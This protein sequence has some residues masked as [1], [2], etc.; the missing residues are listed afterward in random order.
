M[1]VPLVRLSAVDALRGFVA[2]GRRMSIAQGAEDLCLTP[3]ALSKQ[4]TKLEESL[5]VRLLVRGH[6]S[7]A[8]TK[9]GAE[10]YMA[11]SAAF[12]QMQDAVG[13]I[14]PSATG[15]PVTITASIGVTALW[16]LPRL[17]RLHADHPG[18]DVRVAAN[19]A[20]VDLRT[21]DIDLSIRYC[22][23]ADVPDGAVRLFGE[24]IRPVASPLLGLRAIDS[25]EALAEQVL[26]EFDDPRHPWLQW[27]N[28]VAAAG[29]TWKKPRGI[30][31]LNQYDMVI[32]AAM[33]GQGVALGRLELLGPLL[34]AGQLRTPDTP[35]G[36]LPCGHGYWL[37]M[38]ER[39]PRRAVRQIAEWL[40]AQA[41]RD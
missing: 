3:S 35:L 26:L 9:E 8:F 4:I 39:V 5:G 40:E 36:D 28:W 37:L 41:S 18:I 14:L 6:R 22:A 33:A 34:Q 29:W 30:V 13:N 19:N 23:Q 16:L 31:R 25:P 10:L 24:T 38:A 17:G 15:K 12:Q 27:S 2:A 7:I 20:V 21:E 1:S 32:H 11:A